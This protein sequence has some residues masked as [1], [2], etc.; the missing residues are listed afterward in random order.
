VSAAPP[1]RP[2]VGVFRLQL[3]KPS[4]TFIAAQAQALTRYRAIYI[5]RAC[6]GPSPQGAEVA[7]L[8]G[9]PWAA[10]RL[11]WL[12]DAAALQAQLGERRPVILHAHFG[13]DGVCA[14]PLA[15]RLGVPL[16]V[17]LHGFDVTRRRWSLLLSLRPALV[18]AVLG[19]R[20]LVRSAERLV[21]VSA[22]VAGAA[23]RRGAPADRVVRLPIGVDLQRLAPSGPGEAGLVVFVGRLVEKK[24]AGVLLQAFARVAAGRPHARLVLVGDGPLRRR[25]VRQ[26]RRL[27][28]AAAVRFV[29]AASHAEALRW[30]AQA[31]AV[32][33][34]SLVAR[35]GDAEGLP[36]VLLE[37]AALGRAVVASRTGGV[38]EAVQDGVS[39]LLI[40]PADPDGLAAALG[41][42]LDEEP[43]A[44]R[45]GWGAR[46]AMQEG[47][48]LRRQT[49]E[50]E[51]LYDALL[52][53]GDR[54]VC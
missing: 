33:A 3:F 7:T 53:G 17:T 23:E 28:L 31:R 18:R 50:L 6:F 32:A 4:E 45:L 30:L 41:R 5:G 44:A 29:G 13:V 2:L 8:A 20:G 24:G 36:T 42:V 35:N 54:G 10:L 37:A 11:R 43:L 52:A 16:V 25:L 15:R 21:A 12:G 40:P 49:A 26:A 22:S 47:F 38:A 34:P 27:G 39:A 48:D 14:L 46:A 19:W 1:L 51:R 9:R